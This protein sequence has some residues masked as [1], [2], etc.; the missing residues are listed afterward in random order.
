LRHALFK[1]AN[2]DSADFSNADLWNANF[3]QATNLDD[4]VRAALAEPFVVRG[5]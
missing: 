3:E 5:R 4:S 1:G 2:L